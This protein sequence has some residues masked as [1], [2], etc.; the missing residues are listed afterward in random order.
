M[1]KRK[2][3]SKAQTD[4]HVVEKTRTASSD[5]SDDSD[6]TRHS[7]GHNSGAVAALIKMEQKVEAI[8]Q[9][10]EAIQL[11]PKYVRALLWHPVVDRGKR[12]RF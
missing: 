10:S 8:E 11:N 9:C 4:G 5:T 1:Q 6:T 2:R 7:S 12:P 3:T